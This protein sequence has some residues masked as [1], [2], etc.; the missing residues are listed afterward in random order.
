MDTAGE[1]RGM[2]FFLVSFLEACGLPVQQPLAGLALTTL[3]SSGYLSSP[4]LGLFP[5]F[6]SVEEMTSLDVLIS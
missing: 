5:T 2:K 4:L 1:V 3:R 6:T